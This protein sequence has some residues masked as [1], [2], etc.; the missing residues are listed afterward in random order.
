MFWGKTTC[1]AILNWVLSLN[2]QMTTRILMLCIANTCR[3]V[4]QSRSLVTTLRH[5]DILAA[6]FEDHF[7]EQNRIIFR[8]YKIAD[9]F[10]TRFQLW[11]SAFEMLNFQNIEKV[12]PLHIHFKEDICTLLLC[13]KKYRSPCS[14]KRKRTFISL[15][16]L[17][18]GKFLSLCTC[19]R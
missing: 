18:W 14:F 2:L 12:I 11:N 8:C 13:N 15:S 5:Q 7:G 6:R 1:R 9:F 3:I 10:Q 17:A 4:L 16:S 19:T